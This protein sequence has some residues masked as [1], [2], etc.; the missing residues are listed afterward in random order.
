MLE[1]EKKNEEEYEV[2]VNGDLAGDLVFD[3]DQNAWVF[4]WGEDG[5]TYEEDLQESIEELQ[6]DFEEGK[7]DEAVIRFGNYEF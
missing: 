1:F 2:R 4:D 5:T 6:E 3:E 7:D